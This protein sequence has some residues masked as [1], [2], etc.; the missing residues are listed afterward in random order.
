MLS[1]TDYANN[2]DFILS[3]VIKLAYIIS[4]YYISASNVI[5]ADLNEAPLS[6]LTLNLCG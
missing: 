2:F 4:T 1:K 5:Q 3:F 6:K